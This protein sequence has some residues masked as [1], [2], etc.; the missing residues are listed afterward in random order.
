MPLDDSSERR[1][2]IPA[3]EPGT[4]LSGIF[5]V[6]ILLRNNSRQGSK[7]AANLKEEES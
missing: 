1:R 2:E 5:S 4:M 7:T 3:Q 6:L